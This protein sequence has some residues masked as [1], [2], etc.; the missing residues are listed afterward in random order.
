MV[1]SA[2]VHLCLSDTAKLVIAHGKKRKTYIWIATHSATVK[3]LGHQYIVCFTTMI[4]SFS[5]RM[6]II[7]IINTSM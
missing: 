3:N 1:C 2:T 7:T 6:T 5:D 4:Y